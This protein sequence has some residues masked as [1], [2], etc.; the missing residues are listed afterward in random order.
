M[1]DDINV[2]RCGS[3]VIGKNRNI[4]KKIGDYKWKKKSII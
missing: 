4:R 2:D 3:T 1:M